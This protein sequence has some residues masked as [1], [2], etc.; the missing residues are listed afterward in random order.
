M[1]IWKVNMFPE[2]KQHILPI[3]SSMVYTS[4]MAFSAN[5]PN[6]RRCAMKVSLAVD[7]HLQYHQDE[8]PGT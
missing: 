2:S 3:T 4:S 8:K 7:F 5:N 6:Q 1:L